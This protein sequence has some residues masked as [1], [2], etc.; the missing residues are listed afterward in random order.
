MRF[1]L[2]HGRHQ[3]AGCPAGEGIISAVDGHTPVVED[4]KDLAKMYPNRFKRIGDKPRPGDASVETK[5]E[6]I[7][8]KAVHKGAGKWDV[9]KV[10]DGV[11]TKEAINDEFLKKDEAKKM[12]AAGYDPESEEAPL[13]DE[14]EDEAPIKRG[15]TKSDDEDQ[16]DDSD[17]DSDDEESDDEESDDD[18]E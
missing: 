17:D 14:D 8:L 4:D 16:D 13:D 15:S 2:L 1:R 10:V 18:E 6:V 9:F 7:T 11:L 5:P 3:P 12:A